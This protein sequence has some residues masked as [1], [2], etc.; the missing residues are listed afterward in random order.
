MIRS[1][2]AVLTVASAGAP[3]AGD[4]RST[5][6]LELNYN[7]MSREKKEKKRSE[8]TG[9]RKEKRQ[10]KEKKVNTCAVLMFKRRMAGKAILPAVSKKSACT[11]NPLTSKVF[12]CKS[13]TVS[14]V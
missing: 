10:N 8:R 4:A 9:K 14:R 5:A 13:S 6:D 2:D 3:A 12:V 7:N 1:M 11:N